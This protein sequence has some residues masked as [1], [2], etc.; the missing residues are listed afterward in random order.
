M[1]FLFFQTDPFTNE[2]CRPFSTQKKGNDA[3]GSEPKV[4]Q[5]TSASGHVIAAQG[6][7]IPAK[8]PPTQ[9]P[10]HTT[11]LGATPPAPGK[12]HSF[13][14]SILADILD[15]QMPLMERC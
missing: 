9:Y 3:H 15:M 13:Q 10:V 6:A 11:L 2:A 5:R 8:Q 1:V 12:R 14:Y 4:M 7:A